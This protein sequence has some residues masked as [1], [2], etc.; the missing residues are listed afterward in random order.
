MYVVYYFLFSH[1]YFVFS[2]FYFFL[3]TF[4]SFVLSCLLYDMTNN[5]LSLIILLSFFSFFHNF[6]FLLWLLMRNPPSPNPIP[7]TQIYP[8]LCIF[9]NIFH[10][11][12]LLFVPGPSHILHGAHIHI[13]PQKK[14][15]K[16]TQKLRVKREIR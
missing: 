3:F 10:I 12:R 15:K 16:T 4:L 9:S 14:K 2:L 8:S 6:A 5:Y 1:T 11:S 13:H 7:P